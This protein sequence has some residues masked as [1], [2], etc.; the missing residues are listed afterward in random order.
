MFGI[1]VLNRQKTK[2]TMLQAWPFFCYVP[3]TVWFTHLYVS[4]KDIDVKVM[5]GTRPIEAA[6]KQ[7]RTPEVGTESEVEAVQMAKIM[8]AEIVVFGLAM[9]GYHLIVR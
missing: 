8:V 5:Q 6:K 1:I 4:F 7:R 2:M 9:K 3:R